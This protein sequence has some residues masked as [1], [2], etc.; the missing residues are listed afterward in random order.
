MGGIQ[1]PA[2]KQSRFMESIKKIPSPITPLQGSGFHLSVVQGDAP[3]S[4]AL[5][6]ISA[7]LALGI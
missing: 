4:L 1:S 5:A 6:V 3:S 2:L 7:P